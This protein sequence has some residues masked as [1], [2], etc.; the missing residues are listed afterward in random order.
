MWTL[1]IR[2]QMKLYASDQIPVPAKERVTAGSEETN[3]RP[4]KAA[5]ER[6]RPQSG[7]EYWK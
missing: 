1:R 5:I 4:G 7:N 3:G 2:D 6:R